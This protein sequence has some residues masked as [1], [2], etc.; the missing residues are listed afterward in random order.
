[1]KKLSAIICV[2]LLVV[3]LSGCSGGKE[4]SK[5]ELSDTGGAGGSTTAEERGT[6]ASTVQSCEHQWVEATCTTPR[7]CSKCEMI[8]G[9]PLGHQM[10]TWQTS[11]EA[12]CAE[13]GLE[14]AQCTVCGES[15]ERETEKAEH[16]PG[17]WKTVSK[18]SVDPSGDV[19]PGKKV[20]NCKI[21]G[22]EVDSKETTIEVTNSQLNALRRAGEYLDLMAFSKEGLA[23]QLEFEKFS[24]E[25]AEWAV[26][27]CGADWKEQAAKKAQ[28]YLDMMSFSRDGLI[29]QLEFEGFTHKQAVYGVDKV[30]L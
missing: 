19:T 1:M 14:V 10:G 29:D 5:V 17:K 23:D 16:S 22:E 20:K 6:E 21:C 30:G 15:Q 3:V 28:D 8:E 27:N 9:D 7:T 13:A 2:S 12:T 4:A 25:D 24:K 11:K 18:P 26:E